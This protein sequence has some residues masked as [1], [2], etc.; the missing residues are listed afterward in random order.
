[1][2]Q[3]QEMQKL[4]KL[5]GAEV[6]KHLAVAR[7]ELFTLR[8]NASTAHVKDYSRFKTLRKRVARMLTV[9]RSTFVEIKK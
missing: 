7:D 3:K 2:K 1:M 9:L 4:S 6:A 5:D 8:L